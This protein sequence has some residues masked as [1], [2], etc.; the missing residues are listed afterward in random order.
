MYSQERL[1]KA[2]NLTRLAAV[3]LFWEGLSSVNFY[4][5]LP[6]DYDLMK[7]TDYGTLVFI[8]ADILLVDFNELLEGK[9]RVPGFIFI[10]LLYYLEGSLS[11]NNILSEVSFSFLRLASQKAGVLWSF[12]ISMIDLISFLSFEVS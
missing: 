1:L 4:L 12:M 11:E 7:V 3:L 9:Y 5:I 8:V 6:A 2:W 10:R